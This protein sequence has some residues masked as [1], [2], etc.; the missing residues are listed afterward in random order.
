[1]GSTAIELNDF[2]KRAPLDDTSNHHSTAAHAIESL[3]PHSALAI[4]RPSAVLQDPARLRLDLTHANGVLFEDSA[5]AHGLAGRQTPDV[6]SCAATPGLASDAED[7]AAFAREP[8]PPA[9]IE[10]K[11]QDRPT[12]LTSLAHEILFVAVCGTGQ[13]VFG[14]LIGN[15]E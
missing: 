7:Y 14:L 3:K 9:R 13:F 6:H 11:M 5:A 12:V 4:R 2:A 1:M 8:V 15:G 10:G